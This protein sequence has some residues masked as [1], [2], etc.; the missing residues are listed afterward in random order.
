MFLDESVE[1]A[2]RVSELRKMSRSNMATIKTVVESLPEPKLFSLDP[3]KSLY[4]NELNNTLE[5]RIGLVTHN[6]RRGSHSWS[7]HWSTS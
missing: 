4:Q 6:S 2:L 1:E 7:S 5:A 3:K